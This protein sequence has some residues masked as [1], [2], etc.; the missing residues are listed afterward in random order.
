MSVRDNDFRASGSGK[1]D[2]NIDK[3]DKKCIKI[4]FKVSKQLQFQSMAY[5]F[6][7]NENNEP[8]F[9]EMSY[10]YLDTA[11][12]NCPGY[13]DSNLNWH[14]GHY[15][16]QYFQLMDALKMPELKQPEMKV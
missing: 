11:I 9:S 14:E 15:W 3:V 4:A 8:E 13:W 2:Y 10:T 1:I 16:P 12:Y 7:Y 6:I 5:D